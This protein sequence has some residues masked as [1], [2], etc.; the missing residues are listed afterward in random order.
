MNTCPPMIAKNGRSGFS[1]AFAKYANSF[2]NKKPEALC[3]SWHPTIELQHKIIFF[4]QKDRLSNDHS[5]LTNQTCKQDL[6]NMHLCQLTDTPKNATLKSNKQ[7]AY[8][9]SQ[10]FAVPI[11]CQRTATIGET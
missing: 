4:L 2:F 5:S 8:H 7:M 1:R 10:Y 9:I 3:G 6:Y 11:F